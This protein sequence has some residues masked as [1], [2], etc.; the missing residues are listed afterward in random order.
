MSDPTD[1]A[2]PIEAL[3]EL[4]RKVSSCADILANTVS[5][6]ATPERAAAILD[7]L[8]ACPENTRNCDLM[9]ALSVAVAIQAEQASKEIGLPFTTAVS[10][11]ASTLAILAKRAH[12]IALPTDPAHIH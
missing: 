8:A 11:V 7:T 6:Q 10:I 2:A 9:L 5:A 4:A 12:V 3:A 1:P